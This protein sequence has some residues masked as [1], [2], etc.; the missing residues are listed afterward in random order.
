MDAQSVLFD[1]ARFD[2]RGARAWLARHGMAATKAVHKTAGRLRYRLH[3]PATY[4]VL[5]TITITPGV[6]LVV[7]RRPGAPGPRARSRSRKK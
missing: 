3:A 4:K 2:A 7:G 5:R 1:R 6:Q